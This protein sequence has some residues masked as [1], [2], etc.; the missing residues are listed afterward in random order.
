MF[1][2]LS[3]LSH[4]SFVFVP[5]VVSAPWPAARGTLPCLGHDGPLARAGTEI[6][7]CHF[8]FVRAKVYPACRFGAP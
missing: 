5:S 6:E 4:H 1:E 8:V 2:L 7:N 3:N